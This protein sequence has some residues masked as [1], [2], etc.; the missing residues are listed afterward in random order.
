MLETYFAALTLEWS[1]AY[2]LC[3]LYWMAV[4]YDNDRR[5]L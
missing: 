4:Q 2:T 5:D 3:V 1:I